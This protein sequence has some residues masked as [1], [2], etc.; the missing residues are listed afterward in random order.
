MGEL[1]D[2]SAA[3]VLFVLPFAAGIALGRAEGRGRWL[4]RVLFI[5]SIASA[6]AIGHILTVRNPAGYRVLVV[7]VELP[8][9]VGA[10]VASV[11]GTI[12][13]IALGRRLRRPG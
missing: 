8:F 13:G 5:V 11:A 12:A 10:G 9:A 7:L 1:R 6:L 4:A 3:L 2:N